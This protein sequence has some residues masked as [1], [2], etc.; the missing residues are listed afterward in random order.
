M[1]N[2]RDENTKK[3]CLQPVACNLDARAF[4]YTLPHL[5]LLVSFQKLVSTLETGSGL[6]S[7]P[8]GVNMIRNMRKLRQTMR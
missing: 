7:D 4:I 8:N 1:E 6:M 3:L 5:P 2:L